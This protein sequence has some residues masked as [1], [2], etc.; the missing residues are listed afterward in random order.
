M[1]LV[2]VAF[3]Q[4]ARAQKRFLAFAPIAEITMCIRANSAKMESVLRL[5]QLSASLAAA[6]FLRYA[7][8]Q[9]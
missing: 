3:F 8:T 9:N 5:R 1:R 7:N 2:T 4:Q 6:G